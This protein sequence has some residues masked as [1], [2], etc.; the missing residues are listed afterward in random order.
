MNRID[1][2]MNGAISAILISL[3]Y[4]LLQCGI[5]CLIGFAMGSTMMDGDSSSILWCA[6]AC[7]VMSLI[8]IGSGFAWLN[9]AKSKR[10]T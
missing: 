2:I 9:I 4:V 1:D 7:I 6:I 3:G 5:I 8:Q 10:Q